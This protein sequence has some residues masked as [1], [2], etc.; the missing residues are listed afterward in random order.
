MVGEVFIG[1]EGWAAGHFAEPEAGGL[2]RPF[3]KV[4]ASVNAMAF[5]RPKQRLELPAQLAHH[6]G[7]RRFEMAAREAF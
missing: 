3:T 1:L 7:A 2:A 5:I 6:V 4:V